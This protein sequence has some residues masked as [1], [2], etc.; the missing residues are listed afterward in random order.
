MALNI[1]HWMGTIE[2]KELKNLDWEIT[3][4]VAEQEDKELVVFEIPKDRP[5]LI[6]K[7]ENLLQNNVH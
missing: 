3:A 5:D 7:I 2:Q 4:F 1:K 6:G